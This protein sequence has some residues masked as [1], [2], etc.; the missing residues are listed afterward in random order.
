MPDA[1]VVRLTCPDESAAYEPS[2]DDFYALYP[3]KSA[4]K[5]AQKAWL[6]LDERDRRAAIVGLVQWR[7]V[8]EFEQSRRDDFLDHLAY[9]ATWLRGERWTDELPAKFNRPVAVA[10][11]GMGGVAR[12][13]DGPRVALPQHVIDAIARVRAKAAR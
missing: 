10:S 2:F 4:R 13:I 1:Q 8:W 9:P 12:A 7:R 3:R 5:D 11:A 6:A